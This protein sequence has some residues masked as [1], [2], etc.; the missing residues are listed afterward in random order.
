MGSSVYYQKRE[1]M[2]KGLVLQTIVAYIDCTRVFDWAPELLLRGEV[3][4]TGDKS[5]ECLGA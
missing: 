1:K 2:T 4:C 3:R 5:V